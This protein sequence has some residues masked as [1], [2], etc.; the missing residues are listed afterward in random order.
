LAPTFF[1]LDNSPPLVQPSKA[2]RKLMHR[3]HLTCALIVAVIFGALWALWPKA[4]RRASGRLPQAA[5]VW[6]RAWTP[7]VRDAIATRGTNFSELVALGAEV[8]WQRGTPRAIRVPLDFAA[9]RGT[10]RPVGIALRIGPFRGPFATDDEPARFL[11]QLAASMVSEASSNRL[12]PAELQIDFDCAESKLDGYR[13]WIEAI[14]QDAA[15]VPV[16]F[17]ALP[18]WLKRPAFKR[19]VAG[20]DGYV[21][22]VHSL[23]RPRSANTSFTLCD[24]DAALLAVERAARLGR[25]F[26]VALPTYGY[27]MAFDTHG[28][29]AGLNAEGPPQ[30][31]PEDFSVREVRADPEAM[32]GLVRRWMASRPQSLRGL[33]W[34][35]LPVNGESLNWHGSTLIEVM[36]GHAPRALLRAEARQPQPGLVELDLVNEGSADATAAVRLTLRWTGARALAADALQ[37]FDV[38]DTGTNSAQFR[39]TPLFA[40]LVPAERRTVGWVR[41]TTEREVKLEAEFSRN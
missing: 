2:L 40:R 36:N 13:V 7:A 37:G 26:R 22:Q 21:L 14:R 3:R 39:S 33:I 16:T 28:R 27:R 35:R 23:E 29:F 18:A 11:R 9:L 17:T 5:Y 31:W 20:A 41:L 24:A 6:Q 4:V 19:L 25:S 38:T 10:G 34:C 15:P 32:A 12:A 30:A 1:P 8:A